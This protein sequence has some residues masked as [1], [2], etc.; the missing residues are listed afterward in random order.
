MDKGACNE[1]ADRC[2]W[3]CGSKCVYSF[4]TER[5]GH[6]GDQDGPSETMGALSA[7]PYQYDQ[8]IMMNFKL[9]LLSE[10]CDD[11][12]PPKFG[13]VCGTDKI[14]YANECLLNMV[15]CRDVDQLNFL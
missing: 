15:A 7:F 8:Y 10:S 5:L 2:E 14:T 4:E 6:C 13:P 11:S 3:W 9:G 12:C 1:A